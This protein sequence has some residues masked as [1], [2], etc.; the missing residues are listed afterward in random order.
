MCIKGLITFHEFSCFCK[1]AANLCKL[2]LFCGDGFEKGSMLANVK[3]RETIKAPFSLSPP[4]SQD[5]GI[6]SGQL[7]FTLLTGTTRDKTLSQWS[8]YWYWWFGHTIIWTVLIDHFVLN[9]IRKIPVDDDGNGQS[10]D[11][12]ANEGAESTDELEIQRWFWGLWI[13]FLGLWSWLLW[14]WS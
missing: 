1:L 11:E 3:W 2:T 5:N 9:E 10:K 12:D 8:M 6:S 7:L 4:N 14:L 13:W